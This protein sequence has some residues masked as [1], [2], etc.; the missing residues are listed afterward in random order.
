M[1]T[2]SSATSPWPRRDQFQPEFALAQTRF[3]GEQHAQAQDVHEHAV[4]RGAFGE[5]LA[6]V[7]AHQVDDVA[8]RF[9]A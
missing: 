5:V 4:A 1:S 2:A 6:Q 7:A 3:T 8:G 9:A